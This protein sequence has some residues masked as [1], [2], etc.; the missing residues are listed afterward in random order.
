MVIETTLSLGADQSSKIA[1][2]SGDDGPVESFQLDSLKSTQ[3]RQSLNQ[4][5]RSLEKD[6]NTTIFLFSSP[7]E[8]LKSPWPSLITCLANQNLLRLICVDEVHQCVNFGTTFRKTFPNVGIDAHGRKKVHNLLKKYL[9][10]TMLQL[11]AAELIILNVS[12]EKPKGA[13]SLGITDTTPSYVIDSKWDNVAL[14][15]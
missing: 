11:I 5:L 9:L 8:L 1:A 6:A 13:L 2:A 7:E 12:T 14:I 4:C 3:S 10:T 15:P